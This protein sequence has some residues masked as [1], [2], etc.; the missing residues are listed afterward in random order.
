M[1]SQSLRLLTKEIVATLS[2]AWTMTKPELLQTFHQ[3]ALNTSDAT[4]HIRVAPDNPVHDL[5]TNTQAKPS[6]MQSY[7]LE[8]VVPAIL[9]SIQAISEDLINNHFGDTKSISSRIEDAVS[10]NKL[11]RSVASKAHY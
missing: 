3:L 10:N 11:T 7:L 8:K 6:L 9:P 2:F 5:T 1:D 4:R